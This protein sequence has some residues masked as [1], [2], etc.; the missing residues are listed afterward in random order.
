LL[1]VTQH[2]G[3]VPKRVIASAAKQ[4]KSQLSLRAQRSNPWIATAYGL[5][6][7]KEIAWFLAMT[8]AK[9]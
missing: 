5:A 9:Q 7:T 1:T 8:E 3:S 4:S 2:G 6:M